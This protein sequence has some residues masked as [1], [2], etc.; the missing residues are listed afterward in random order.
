MRSSRRSRT[1]CGCLASRAI[2][3]PPLP[4]QYRR[5]LQMVVRL[6]VPSYRNSTFVSHFL[7]DESRIEDSDERHVGAR[8]AARPAMSNRFDLH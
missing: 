1:T 8:S 6:L 4:M 3:F 7:P 2:R 5:T